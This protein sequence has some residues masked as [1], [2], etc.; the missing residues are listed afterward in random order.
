MPAIEGYAVAGQQVGGTESRKAA[1][2]KESKEVDNRSAEKNEQAAE[3][4]S[5]Q[6]RTD[7][8]GISVTA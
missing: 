7:D 4:K 6:G 5:N 3:Q 8:G 1:P 2:K